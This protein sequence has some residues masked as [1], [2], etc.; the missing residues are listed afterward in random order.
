M[1][2]HVFARRGGALMVTGVVVDLVSAV[3]AVLPP[4]AV[5]I[6]VLVDNVQSVDARISAP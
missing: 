5:V 4:F 1:L 3:A 2:R 6:I